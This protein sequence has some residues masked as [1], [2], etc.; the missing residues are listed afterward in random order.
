MNTRTFA[1]VIAIAVLVIIGGWLA[2]HAHQRNRI[3]AYLDCYRRWNSN[4]NG[5]SIDKVCGP[6]PTKDFWR[7]EA[8]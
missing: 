7:N 4:S 1:A 5:Q 2:Y 6:P 3:Q 8:N